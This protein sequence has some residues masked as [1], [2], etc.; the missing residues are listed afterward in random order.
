MKDL[1]QCRE[2]IDEIDDKIIELF[3]KRM[4]IAAEVAA[5][6][7]ASGKA[8]FD[9]QREEEK[10]AA[11]EQKASDAYFGRELRELFS[12]IMSISKKYQESLMNRQE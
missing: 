7:K 12:V 5:Y 4:Q 11:I 6:K 10:L 1:M 2:E 3:E 9:K 8:V